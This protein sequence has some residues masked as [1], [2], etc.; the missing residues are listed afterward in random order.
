MWRSGSGKLVV[1]KW[2]FYRT[3]DNQFQSLSPLSPRYLYSGL[4]DMSMAGVVVRRLGVEDQAAGSRGIV[5]YVGRWGPIEQVVV[6]EWRSQISGANN[7]L[8]VSTLLHT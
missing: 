2:Y 3:V 7:L 8:R 1:L 5:P 6:H 4:D